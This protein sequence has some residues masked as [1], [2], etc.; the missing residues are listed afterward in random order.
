VRFGRQ[1]PE[2]RGG[3]IIE[4]FETPSRASWEVKGAV[5]GLRQWR[6]KGD[7]SGPI[8]Y[9][10]FPIEWKLFGNERRAIDDIHTFIKRARGPLTV[11]PRPSLTNRPP[12]LPPFS[13]TFPFQH[14]ARDA[15]LRAAQKTFEDVSTFGIS[16][17]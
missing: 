11:P 13:D 1:W 2:E 4:R 3:N 17:R 9:N 5:R 6:V 12:N 15:I 8:K 16:F 7:G 10:Y 14:L